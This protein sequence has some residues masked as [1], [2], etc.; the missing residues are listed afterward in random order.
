M[1]DT[2]VFSSSD[3]YLVQKTLKERIEFEGVGLHSGVKA[4]L[5]LLP[6]GPNHGILFERTDLS[7]R[8]RLFAHY[9]AVVS[10]TLATTL[11]HND[12]EESRVGT[13]EHLL[14]ALYAMG[15]NNVMIQIEGP[16]IPILDGSAYEFIEG[17]LDAGLKAQG[18]TTPRLRILKPIK[19]YQEGAICELLPRN[20]LRL[21]TSVD[22]PHPSIG[23]QTFALEL[24]PDNFRR[25]VC[26]ARTF[27][28]QKDVDRLRSKNLAL[29]ASL[30][31]VL[32][33][34]DDK[35]LN[36]EG[37]RFENECVRHKLLDAM[38]DLALCGSWIEGEMVSFRGGHKIHLALLKYLRKVPSYWEIVPARPI[39]N[40]RAFKRSELSQSS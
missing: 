12:C 19:I 14:S 18:Y 25:E 1:P 24:T 28:F 20:R 10:T 21:T 5:R 40:I 27:G 23:L 31:N 11:G 2:D 13:V 35:V 37:M 36:P 34:S 17:I 3:S 6:A 26:K 33:F 39:E 7:K 9:D 38:G 22:F 16:E 8:P 29:G 30:E 32:A 15:V 4:R